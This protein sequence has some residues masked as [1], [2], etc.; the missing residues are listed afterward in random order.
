MIVNLHATTKSNTLC[1]LVLGS[2]L[3]EIHFGNLARCL[4]KELDLTDFNSES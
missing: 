3:E 2:C 1:T 4:F